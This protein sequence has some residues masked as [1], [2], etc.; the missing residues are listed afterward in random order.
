MISSG[1]ISDLNGML[2]AMKITEPYSPAPR[3]KASA[4]PVASAG[5][6][7]GRITRSEGLPARCAERQRRLLD[8]ARDFGQHRLDCSHHERQADEG[9]R[10]DDA[11]RAGRRRR[12]PI[13][14]SSRPINPGIGI[15]RGQRDAGDRGRAARTAGRRALRTAACAGTRSAPAP[16]RRAGRTRH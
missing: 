7:V 11:G 6:I 1:A 16:R 2:P 3:A 5:A 9:Q 13:V 15:E 12:S 14:A 4:K 10:D 8:L